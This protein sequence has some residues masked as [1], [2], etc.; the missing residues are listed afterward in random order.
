MDVNA[1]NHKAGVNSKPVSKRM[2]SLKIWI[3]LKF[4]DPVKSQSTGI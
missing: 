4:I 2:D 1:I 3:R